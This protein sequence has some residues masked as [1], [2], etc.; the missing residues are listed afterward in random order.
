MSRARKLAAAS[1]VALIALT[2]GV[3]NAASPQPYGT[4]DYGGFNA[5]LPPGTNG[6][7]NPFQLANFEATGA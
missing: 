5:I 2:N 4:N 7:A 3:A 1:A 6:L